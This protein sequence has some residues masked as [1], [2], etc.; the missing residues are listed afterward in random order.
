[1]Y[2]T[3]ELHVVTSN[4]NSAANSNWNVATRCATDEKASIQI[5]ELE[6]TT[7]GM[8]IP[9]SISTTLSWENNVMWS[10]N[11]S[12]S[13]MEIDGPE[14]RNWRVLQQ[15][16]EYSRIKILT[17][18]ANGEGNRIFGVCIYTYILV[19]YNDLTATSLK[20]WLVRGIIPN[21]PYFRLVNYCNLPRYI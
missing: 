15:S 16:I 5:W 21:L 18:M 4:V 10:Y 19:N 11:M 12:F 8:N 6:L 14:H 13:T 2:H 20:S 17:K 9:T 7:P 3:S 1:M